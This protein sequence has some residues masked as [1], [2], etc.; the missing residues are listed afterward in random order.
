MSGV[1]W[2]EWS[3]S[4]FEYQVNLVKEAFA[5]WAVICFF[6]AKIEMFIFKNVGTSNSLRYLLFGKLD[7]IH[8]V[9]EWLVNFD[10]NR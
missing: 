1:K 3:S 8:Q 10:I 7:F 6:V 4:N 2:M 9:L 5:I